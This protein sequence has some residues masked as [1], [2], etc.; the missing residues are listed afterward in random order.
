MYWEFHELGGRQAIRKGDWKLI[1]YDVLKNG[2]Y[3]LYNLKNDV[4]ET[5]DLAIQMPEKVAEL[6]KL[7]ESSR[8]ESEDFKFK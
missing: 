6:A 4:S 5:K 1:K 2:N 7:L 3:Q 8:T